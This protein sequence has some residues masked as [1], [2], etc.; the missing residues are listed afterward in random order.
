M[1]TLLTKFKLFFDD[2]WI[3]KNYNIFDKNSNFIIGASSTSQE[4]LEEFLIFK[5]HYI[6]QNHGNS[7]FTMDISL[8]NLGIDIS[9]LSDD[10]LFTVKNGI[11]NLVTH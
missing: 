1:P 9:N 3:C 8:E 11:K 7:L 5:N 2:Y 6:Y 10:V 4:K